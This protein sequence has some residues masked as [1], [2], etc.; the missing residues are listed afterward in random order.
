MTQ[1]GLTPEQVERRLVQLT[2]EI[3]RAAEALRIAR[4]AEA[5]LEIVHRGAHARALLSS[6]C[7]R[8]GRGEGVAT[9]AAVE[10]W[11]RLRTEDAY[12]DLRLATAVRESA[13]DGLRATLA[14]AEVVRSLRASVG[15]ALA[16]AGFSG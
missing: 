5:S 11:V 8:V 4:E 2:G 3:T 16:L 1:D 7:P 14:T 15:G 10:A 13:Q 12:R 9:V 6:E